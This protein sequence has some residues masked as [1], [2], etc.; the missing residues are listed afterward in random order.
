MQTREQPR[1][2]LREAVAVWTGVGITLLAVFVT[3]QRYPASELYHVSQDGI[4]GAFGQ[5]LVV[6][7]YP[8]A[9]VAIAL[10]GVALAR[11][12]SDST[13][14]S[15]PIL[16]AAALVGIA[17]CAA[18][19]FSV[20]Q[21]GMD[22]KPINALPALGIAIALG[23]TGLALRA[24]PVGGWRPWTR[25]DG[26]SLVAG[27]AG[28][29]GGLPVIFAQ[30]GI[31]VADV[32]GLRSIFMSRA[33]EDG[34]KV[35][36]VHIGNHHGFA[37][38]FMLLAGLLL[39]REL[40]AARERAI[41]LVFGWYVSLL[42]IYGAANLV[43]DAWGEQI[44]KRGWTDHTIRNLIRPSLTLDWLSIVIG[45]VLF[46]LIYFYLPHR[47]AQSPSELPA[48]PSPRRRVGHLPLGHAGR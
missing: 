34:Q 23:L 36:Y 39:A 31:Y 27:I 37:G 5:A 7:N 32:P 9:L 20:D 41:R 29:L 6:A 22:A 11:L 19:A 17:L 18:T 16:A 10:I 40:I 14:Q 13:S 44:V 21:G 45:T 24:G 4:G 46:W 48:A 8:M 42:T 26:L 35:V 38:V 28:V 15:R 25:R 47:H 33:V 1:F 12:W 2:A 43:Q 30:A 3:A